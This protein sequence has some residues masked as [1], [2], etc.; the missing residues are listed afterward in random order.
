[1]S[2]A[3]REGEAEAVRK[4]KASERRRLAEKKANKEAHYQILI[5]ENEKLKSALCEAKKDIEDWVYCKG[6][7]DQSSKVINLIDSLI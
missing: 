1:M 4:D 6:E 7:D 2:L 3:E 5:T